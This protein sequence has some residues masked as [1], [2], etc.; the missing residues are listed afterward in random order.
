MLIKVGLVSLTDP[1]RRFQSFLSDIKAF[2]D[3]HPNTET[4]PFSFDPKGQVFD[5]HL[6]PTLN[7][8][9]VIFN[10][11]SDPDNLIS[12][13][14]RDTGIQITRHAGTPPAWKQPLV[15]QLSTGNYLPW[16][17]L[18]RREGKQVKLRPRAQE[19]VDR[20]II[21]SME[22]GLKTL[23]VA[24]KAFQEVESLQGFCVSDID[25]FMPPHNAMLINHHHAEGRN[26]FQECDI[27]FVFH[28][29]PNHHG[30][31]DASKRIYRNPE[32]PLDFTREKRTVIIGGVSFEKNVYIDDRVQAVYN[33]ECRQRLMQSAM[34]LRPNIHIG[35]IIVF[36][37]AEP[38]DIPVTPVPFSLDDGEGFTG[39]WQAFHETLQAA[40]TRT[41][42]ERIEVGVSKSKAYRDAPSSKQTKA[43][44]NIE[45]VRRYAAGQ[46]QQEIADALNIGLATVN[47]VLKEQSF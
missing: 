14:Y 41:A 12:E 32:I 35:K 13:V 33:R 11:A 39:D 18:L 23:I 21:P 29:E 1:P 45:I 26:D 4:A 5:F 6:K 27:E 30:I 9:R 42:K 46:T 34:R 44:R 16:K 7:H 37:T 10:T 22:A 36:L 17:S 24:P 43:E 20:F 47:R 15:F 3:E 25:D 38:V 8:R 28:Y 19:I 2:I 40:D 31:I